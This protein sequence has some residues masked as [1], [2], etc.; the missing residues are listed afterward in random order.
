MTPNGSLELSVRIRETMRQDI[1]QFMEPIFP[2]EAIREYNSSDD[3]KRRDRVYNTENTLLT[4]VI[5]A[6]KEDRSLQNSVRI[7][8]EIFCKNRESTLQTALFLREEQKMAAMA[9]ASTIDTSHAIQIPISKIKDIS[10]NTAAYSK[11]R[12]RIEQGLINNVFK[13][14][15]DFA[16]LNCVQKWHGRNVFNTDGTYFQMQDSPE[17]PEK[18]RVQK[19]S[20]GKT[21][22]YPQGLLQVL[23]QHGSG[24][25]YRYSIKG[26]DQSE[27]VAIAELLDELP[28]SSTLLADD[29]YNCY[30]FYSLSNDVGVDLIVPDKKDR[31][32]RLVRTIAP[33][34]E[35]VEIS[36][37]NKSRPLVANQKL[38]PKILL[39]R[40]S[41]KDPEHPDE[42]RALFTT[43][44]DETIER[45]E[46]IHKFSTRWDIEITILE[47]KTMMGINIARSKSE[48]MVFK[49]IGVALLAYNLVRK[50]VAKSALETPFSPETDFF[51]K[52]Y[53]FDTPSLVDRKGRV[54]SRWSPGRPVVNNSKI[55]G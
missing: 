11:A 13:A 27:L 10:A 4:M 29:L 15:T 17:I 40:I 9:T 54:Y 5:T 26:R 18:Y 43:I 24:C 21:Q 39:R 34:D 46:F 52:L 45:Q 48:E 2:Y 49:E 37:S 50:I 53:T 28:K 30:A 51:E 25:L 55:E 44:F 35:I 33:G 42:T 6:L 32:Y 31:S 47:I 14:S 38:P 12:G 7:F 8:Q 23:T 16:D 41:Y 1:L 3:I 19:S 20:D 36:K 22:G